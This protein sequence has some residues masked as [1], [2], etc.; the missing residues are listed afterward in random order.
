MSG[1]PAEIKTLGLQLPTSVPLEVI[2]ELLLKLFIQ[3]C[4]VSV[5]EATTS[6]F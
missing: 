4:T 6:V 1:G 2:V 5:L 3:F